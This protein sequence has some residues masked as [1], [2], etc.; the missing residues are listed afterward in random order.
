MLSRRRKVNFHGRGYCFSS[1]LSQGKQ[2]PSLL[3][4]SSLFIL[5]FP[6]LP[7]QL[8][9]PQVNSINGPEAHIKHLETWLL[10]R[11]FPV[12]T[13]IN[14]CHCFPSHHHFPPPPRCDFFPISSPLLR[15]N[16]LYSAGTSRAYAAESTSATG[17]INHEHFAGGGGCRQ[18]WV[19]GREV[20]ARLPEG[21][22]VRVV[23]SF[24]G[25][26]GGGEVGSRCLPQLH[27]PECTLAQGLLSSVSVNIL[28]R[29]CFLDGF[30]SD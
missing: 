9:P 6:F 19:C 15:P 30:I 11:L 25:V 26:P 27:C 29:L 21:G 16:I 10:G 24:Y 12:S 7:S 18:R 17:E 3:F 5:L 8:F 1:F 13:A 23:Y 28:W 20:L 2:Y 4:P 22:S 14:N